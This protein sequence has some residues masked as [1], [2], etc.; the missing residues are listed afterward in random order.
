MTATSSMSGSY[1]VCMESSETV[2][3]LEIDTA[4][5]FRRELVIFQI[6]MVS[7]AVL[8]VCIERLYDK[9]QSTYVFILYSVFAFTP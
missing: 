1:N 9:I 8:G 6:I 5:Y 7:I 3:T 4:M 2:Y